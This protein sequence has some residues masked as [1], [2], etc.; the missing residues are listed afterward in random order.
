MY[1]RKRYAV[2]SL[3]LMQSWDFIN[4]RQFERAINEIEINK[5]KVL[6]KKLDQ[7]HGLVISL[8]NY[9]HYGDTEDERFH[10]ILEELEPVLSA[11]KNI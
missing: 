10:K 6:M 4:E 8:K 11:I 1:F 2:E 9:Q 3:E 5:N 7:V